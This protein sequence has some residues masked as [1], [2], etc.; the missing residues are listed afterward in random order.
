MSLKNLNKNIIINE[1][2]GVRAMI[3]PQ[4][5]D[6]YNNIFSSQKSPFVSM[7]NVKEKL[8]LPPITGKVIN[9]KN[10][11]NNV[12]KNNIIKPKKRRHQSSLEKYCSLS[13]DKQFWKKN[14]NPFL[15][16]YNEKNKFNMTKQEIKNELEIEEAKGLPQISD[17]EENN[18]TCQP[19]IFNRTSSCQFFNK[20]NMGEN[21]NK[22]I[23]QINESIEKNSQRKQQVTTT[24]ITKT[25]KKDNQNDNL[26]NEKEVQKD[27]K[28][29]KI[30]NNEKQPSDNITN[31]KEVTDIKKKESID[32]LNDEGDKIDEEEMKDVLGYINSLDYEKYFRDREIRE[33]LQLIKNKMEKDLKEKEEKEEKENKANLETF[34]DSQREETQNEAK[35]EIVQINE[36]GDLQTKRVPI[37]SEEEIKKK[38][39]IEQFKIAEKIAKDQVIIILCHFSFF[40]E[41]KSNSFMSIY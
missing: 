9:H 32:I 29:Q 15:E 41:I 14:I 38:E 7:I 3:I 19:K 28:Q 21:I 5:S 12:Y 22:L 36:S 39:K 8:G 25:S 17:W 37:V 16:T 18:Y 24:K 20:F 11:N 30:E 34:N 2:Q 10:L 31:N 33:A 13:N 1:P 27:D 35:D 23:N 26:N 6:S 40:I 4:R